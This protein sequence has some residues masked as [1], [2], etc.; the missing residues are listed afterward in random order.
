MPPGNVVASSGRNEDLLG[1][2]VE[3]VIKPSPGRAHEFLR[4]RM[5]YGNHFQWVYGDYSRELKVLGE[6]LS[7]TVE[8]F[9]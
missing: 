5:I 8:V 2:S 3:A 1:C 6:M 4:R 9:A 7:L